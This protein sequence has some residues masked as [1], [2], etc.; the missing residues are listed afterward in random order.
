MVDSGI[1][2]FVVVGRRGKKP[3]DLLKVMEDRFRLAETEER[4][5][6]FFDAII[7]ESVNH[8]GVELL[9]RAHK[10]AVSFRWKHHIMKF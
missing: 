8:V 7:E 6:I 2:A 3:E 5:G 1:E 10:I 4:A 9:E